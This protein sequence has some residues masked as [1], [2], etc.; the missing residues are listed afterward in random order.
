MIDYM[1]AILKIEYRDYTMPLVHS[2]SKR[3]AMWQWANVVHG[4]H[5][6]GECIC[7]YTTG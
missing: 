1:T 6:K 7:G 4:H 3:V 5:F 2:D